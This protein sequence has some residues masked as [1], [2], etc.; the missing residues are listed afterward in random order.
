MS[1]RD[2]GRETV[3][4]SRIA[5]QRLR[6]QRLTRLGFRQPDEVVAWFGAVQAQEYEPAKWALGLRMKKRSLSAEIQHAFDQGSILRTHVMRPTWHFVSPAD[7]R[8][9]IELTGSRVQRVMSTYDRQLGLDDR[10][11]VRGTSLIEAALGDG[12]HLT[13][14]ELGERLR[15]AGLTLD[16]VRLAHMA[17]YA[18]LEGV[19]CS[20]P[21][22]GKQST[23][24]LVAERAP[25]AIRLSRDEA[26]AT[27]ARRYFSSHG[28]A[29]MRDFVWWSGL[30]TADAKRGLEMNTAQREDVDGR[31]YW[32]IGDPS[33]GGT[34]DDLVHLLPIYDEYIVAYRDRDAV[35]HAPS[36]IRAASRPAN[37]VTFQHA[38]VIGGQVAG[39]WR[40]MQNAKAAAIDVVP[41]RRLSRLEREA[42][43]DAAARY[44][45][46]LCAPVRCSIR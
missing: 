10:T 4:H 45:Q 17:M 9:L 7:I 21:R 2:R 37:S 23:Y 40:R 38:L 25:K 3:T 44:E 8:W 1:G 19:I 30:P 15:H 26:L 16:R 28:P 29:T 27:L 39:T 5:E 32:T 31:T 13:R 35:P 24:A 12:N 36:T 11:F 41:L 14:A 42:V 6:N 34:R 33:R 18:E 46:F 20:G 43:G 22:R